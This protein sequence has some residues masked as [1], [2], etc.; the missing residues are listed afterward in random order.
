MSSSSNNSATLN[1]TVLMLIPPMG[2]DSQFYGPL[3]DA[4]PDIDLLTPDYPPLDQL[5]PLP[6]TEVLDYLTAH[7][8]QQLQ[9]YLTQTAAP[10][11]SA[12]SASAPYVVAIGG[13]SLG[14]TLSIRLNHHLQRLP[15]HT[16]SQPQRVFLMAS[17]GLRVSRARRETIELAIANY[18]PAE[19]VLK[20]MAIDADTMADSTFPVQFQTMTPAVEAYWNHQARQLRSLVADPLQAENFVKM[21]LAALGVDYE[22]H[23]AAE[24]KNY[25]ILWSEQDKVFSRRMYRKYQDIASQARFH[26]LDNI[27]HYAALEDPHRIAALIR[28]DLLNQI[29]LNSLK[30]N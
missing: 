12:P 17:G 24:C 19:F 22:A 3:R 4:L 7:F 14:A 10:S 9:Q 18:S 30:L 6:V 1:H 26:L 20:S 15:G 27:G 21:T 11:A 28:Q 16:H 23:L 2:H 13:V 25:S 5:A 8:Q 29:K